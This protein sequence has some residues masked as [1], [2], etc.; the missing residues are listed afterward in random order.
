M[1]HACAYTAY[2]WFCFRHSKQ[3]SGQLS[4]WAFCVAAAPM[5]DFVHFM[6]DNAC[7]AA[8]SDCQA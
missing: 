6:L 1:C 7:A 5:L 3:H 2:S 8:A 4:E